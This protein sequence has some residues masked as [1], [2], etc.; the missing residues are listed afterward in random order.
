[1]RYG[2]IEWIWRKGIYKK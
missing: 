1:F 2:P